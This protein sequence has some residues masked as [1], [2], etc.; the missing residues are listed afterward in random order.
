[1]SSTPS[2]LAS[3]QPWDLV[4]GA[5][6]DDLAPAFTHFAEDALRRAGVGAGTRVLDVAAG[7]G[8]LALPAAR[9]GAR[10]SALDFSPEMI[11]RLRAQA[12]REGRAGEIEAVV[13]DGM[14]L[15]FAASA[16][17]AAFSMFG[18]IFF[19]DRDRG[20]REIFRVLRPGGRALVSSWTPVARVPLMAT[21]FA[22]VGSFVPQMSGPIR[23]PMADP[24]ECRAEMEAAGFA[25]AAVHEVET[26][27]D[28]PSTAEFWQT[29]QR[30]SA[31]LALLQ[32]AFGDAWAP[33][34]AGVLERMIAA[35][36]A[37]PQRLAMIALLTE[38]VK[39]G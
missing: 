17:D 37:G 26:G 12:E 32:R 4:A 20:L 19:P 15:P 24:V 8:T 22:A 6:V 1:M 3:P 25:D 33:I 13:G 2:P 27:V 31:P 16:F 30:C 14:D 5:Y 11:A 9:A 36:G 21:M 29:Q 10:V 38:G 34:G 18:L 35:H 23:L 39:A 7:P 28:F